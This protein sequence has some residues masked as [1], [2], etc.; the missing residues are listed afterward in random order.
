MKNLLNAPLAMMLLTIAGTGLAGCGL[1]YLDEDDLPSEV[2]VR[3]ENASDEDIF[4][5]LDAAENSGDAGS[6]GMTPQG[7]SGDATARVK[8]GGLAAK[9]SVIRVPPHSSSLGTVTCGEGLSV[10]AEV[11]DIGGI[12]VT[13]AGVGA[14]ADGFDEGS[15][16]LEGERLLVPGVHF[17]CSDTLIVR[18]GAGLSGEIERVPEGVELPEPDVGDD[19]GSNDNVDDGSGSADQA[20]G[21]RLQ[22]ATDSAVEFVIAPVDEDGEEAGEETVIRVP[23]RQFS[24]GMAACGPTY[25]VSATVPSPSVVVPVTLLGAGSGTPGF[26]GGSVGEEGERIL[27]FSEHYGCGDAIVAT[28]TSDGGASSGDGGAVGSGTVEVYASGESIPD[29]DLGDEDGGDD[30][31]ARLVVAIRNETESFVQ[32]RLT[33]EAGSSAGTAVDVRLPP[34]G[35]STGELACADSYTVAA[36]HLESADSTAE[37]GFHT[38]VLTGAGTGTEG[39]DGDN[40]GTDNTRQVLVGTHLTCDAVLVI[41]LSATNNAVDPESGETTFGIGDGVL[42]VE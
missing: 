5:T 36:F 40:V 17:A 9:T 26:D 19:G 31:S 8:S 39:F 20:V 28:L 38:I 25:V 37:E 1:G 16:G 29:P 22:N 6:D 15:L 7:E 27:A 14:G 2:A 34:A 33:P 10:V 13:L 18:I 35:T 32:V 11:G 23:A 3:I 12:P 41:T 21:F 30:G 4:V 24:S 42:A